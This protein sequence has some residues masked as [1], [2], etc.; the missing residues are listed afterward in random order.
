MSEIFGFTEV[1]FKIVEFRITT[2]VFAEE[3]PVANAHGKIRQV[4]VAVK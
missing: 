1:G 2:V 3:F 4:V